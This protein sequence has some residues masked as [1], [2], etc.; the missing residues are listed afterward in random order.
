MT[1]R[2]ARL[3]FIKRGYPYRISNRKWVCIFNRSGDIALYKYKRS[4]SQN[5]ADIKYD[6]Q[7]C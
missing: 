3:L 7:Q 6:N 4:A 5:R 1:N 2:E